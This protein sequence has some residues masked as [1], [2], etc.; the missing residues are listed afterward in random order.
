MPLALFLLSLSAMAFMII[1]L[2]FASSAIQELIRDKRRN[3]D[4]EQGRSGKESQHP[5]DGSEPAIG[6]D[7]SP[8]R[9]DAVADAIDA[10]HNKRDS[11]ERDRAEREQVT[12]IVLTAT[13]VF[14][15]LAAGAAIVSG[16]IFYGQL[17]DARDD[18]TATNRAFVF[19]R[20]LSHPQDSAQG[21]AI[22]FGYFW[23]N[24]GKSPSRSLIVWNDCKLQSATEKLDFSRHPNE[25]RFFLGPRAEQ[26]ISGCRTAESDFEN[27]G[28]GRWYYVFGGSTYQDVFGD[29]H[30]FEFCYQVSWPAVLPCDG[31]N[32]NHNC[33]DKDCPGF[34]SGESRMNEHDTAP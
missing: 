1:L 11:H 8:R 6:N 18:F 26:Y 13:A 32:G 21:G 25:L 29:R 14:A 20:N 10:Y 12:I 16:W 5:D 30:R 31:I 22:Q 17:A 9:G 28:A 2:G 7:P 4:D 23:H 24:S 3:S 34:K 19:M 27:L 33:A 15:F